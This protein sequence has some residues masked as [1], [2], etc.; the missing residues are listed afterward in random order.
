[1]YFRLAPPHS[2]GAS[3]S[4]LDVT[5]QLIPQQPMLDPIAQ[6]AEVEMLQQQV[7][8]LSMEL[9]AQKERLSFSSV[10][11]DDAL[12]NH[13]T[14][15][16]SANM[17]YILFRFCSYFPIVYY[18]SWN[19]DIITK[20]DQLFITLQKLRCGYTSDA[21]AWHYGVSSTTIRNIF[22]TWVH[23]LWEILF[24]GC[25]AK[26][27]S[28]EKNMTCLPSSFAAF[29][30]CRVVLDCTEIRCA[31]PKQF[32]HQTYTYSH[33]KHYHTHKVLIGV[34]PN[35]VITYI[36][37]C[38][39]GSISDKAIVQDCGIVE[40]LVPGD[41]VLAD[42]GF[43][44]SDLLPA[45][46]TLNIPPFLSSVQ[47]TREQCILTHNIARARIHVE[48]ANCRLKQFSILDYIPQS[49][50]DLSSKLVQV[51]G[52]LVNLQYPLIREIEDRL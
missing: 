38:Y 14:G 52:A 48:R 9:A 40:Q 15:L 25:M 45:G 22:L 24:K 50:R 32:S 2:E 49:Y 6:R 33:Y 31:V 1:M 18:Y 43:L 44:I 29:N 28:R 27:P 47:F 12:V 46:V 10:A 7:A 11:H 36:S 26:M 5:E 21:L 20:E 37:D 16:P 19:V 41:M 30:N 35:G 13:L 17:F 39:P 8:S 34:A 42:K 4:S 51:C 23:L 3:S